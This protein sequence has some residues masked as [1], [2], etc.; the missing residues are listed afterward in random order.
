M[1]KSPF[2]SILYEVTCG[3]SWNNLS[4]TGAMNCSRGDRNYFP[5]LG[6]VFT[7]GLLPEVVLALVVFPPEVVG[8]ELQLVLYLDIQVSSFEFD[9]FPTGVP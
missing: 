3:F 9:C 2:I 5:V 4:A 1:I 6:I 7:G 8:W